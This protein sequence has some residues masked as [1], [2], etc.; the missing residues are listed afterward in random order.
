VGVYPDLEY[1]VFLPNGVCDEC[2]SDS[3]IFDIETPARGM[4]YEGVVCEKCGAKK[5]SKIIRLDLWLKPLDI[6]IDG[7]SHKHRQ[8]KDEERDA[9]LLSIGIKTSRWTNAQ[10]MRDADAIAGLIWAMM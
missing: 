3:L 9:Y 1:E 7:A 8:V 10:V 6:E 5:K 4:G 2:N